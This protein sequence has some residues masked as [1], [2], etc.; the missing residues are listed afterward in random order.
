[1]KKLWEAELENQVIRQRGKPGSEEKPAKM[2]K[3]YITHQ[4]TPGCGSQ[5]RTLPEYRDLDLIPSSH[6]PLV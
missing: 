5:P 1:V 4:K 3:L 6:D 2:I